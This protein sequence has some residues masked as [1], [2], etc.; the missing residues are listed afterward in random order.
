M[1]LLRT[2]K[3]V[4]FDPI[5]HTRAV[6][7]SMRGECPHTRVHR[8]VCVCKWGRCFEVFGRLSR[9][10]ALPLSPCTVCRT[11][12]RPSPA[13]TRQCRLH[14]ELS[15]HAFDITYR[16]IHRQC[17]RRAPRSWKPTIFHI[18]LHIAFGFWIFY[19]NFRYLA[20]I[21]HN[22]QIFQLKPNSPTCAMVV[23]FGNFVPWK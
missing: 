20:M 19:F 10:R 2:L 11:P 12:R 3:L 8:V 7:Q 1:L 22:N 6:D 4:W 15:V 18:M 14:A 17:D 16:N 23:G 13:R 9:E 21:V 5:C